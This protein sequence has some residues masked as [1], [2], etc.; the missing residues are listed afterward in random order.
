MSDKK[1]EASVY[2]LYHWICPKCQSESG[3]LL[4]Q[5]QKLNIVQLQ[6]QRRIES[7]ELQIV[8]LMSL[9]DLTSHESSCSRQ[10]VFSNLAETDPAKSY[11]KVT[12]SAV[13]ENVH[14]PVP[15]ENKE[16]PKR[17]VQQYRAKASEFVFLKNIGNNHK[18]SVTEKSNLQKFKEMIT[19][20]LKL[21]KVCF[22]KVHDSSGSITVGFPNSFNKEKALECLGQL[23]LSSSGY[24][25]HTKDKQLPKIT[26][27]HIPLDVAEMETGE[28]NDEKSDV[29]E[30]ILIKNEE[31]RN[32]CGLGHTF[33]IPKNFKII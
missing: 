17:L 6:Q 20:S 30:C 22:L 19:V 26:V 32:L 3:K 28:G 9:S 24:E 29:K 15:N 18:Q 33:D 31:L 13:P 8:K 11:A 2:G 1:I 27:T 4:Q 21:V 12:S 14:L 25:I 5:M 10:D 7:M 23:D 16:K